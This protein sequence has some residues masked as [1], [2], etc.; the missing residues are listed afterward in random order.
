MSTIKRFGDKRVVWMIIAAA[1]LLW[2]PMLASA[3]DIPTDPA[4]LKRLVQEAHNKFKDD[5]S[6]KPADYIPELAK[7][8]ADLFGVAIVTAKGEIYNA[9]D[10]E[11]AF[12]IQSVSKPS[13]RRRSCRSRAAKRS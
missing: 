13:P 6:G 1:L 5:K 4:T 11:Y 9:G 8:P 3:A 12:T 10:V 2:V 7:V